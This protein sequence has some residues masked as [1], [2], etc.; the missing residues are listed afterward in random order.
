MEA[1]RGGADALDQIEH[2]LAF[3]VAH[4]IAENAPEQPDIG[5]EPNILLKE[6]DILATG[7]LDV[8]IGGH[9]LG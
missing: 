9:D 4:G 2:R 8:G 1:D 5:A 3:L 6:S 7:G